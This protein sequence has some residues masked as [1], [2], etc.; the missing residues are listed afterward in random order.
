[1]GLQS[2]TRQD[3]YIQEVSA[4]YA[5]ASLQLPGSVVEGRR[6]SLLVPCISLCMCTV[7]AAHAGHH[8][9][10]HS[11][12]NKNVFTKMF[13]KVT[14]AA[15]AVAGHDAVH[16]ASRP[17]VRQHETVLDLI[18]ARQ[19]QASHCQT[20]YIEN[21]LLHEVRIRSPCV[22]TFDLWPSVRSM[23]RPCCPCRARCTSRGL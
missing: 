5:F 9:P 11:S 4:A 12:G 3:S 20:H 17:V 15:A 10:P 14:A 19:G 13:G 16:R 23:C 22:M 1:M 8:T 2:G 7:R 18:T 6:R 21:C